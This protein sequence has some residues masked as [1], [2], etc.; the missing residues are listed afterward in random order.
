M[1]T[2]DLAV[3][4]LSVALVFSAGC[5]GSPSAGKKLAEKQMESA[6]N[7]GGAGHAKVDIGSSGNVDLSGL[8]AEFH[9]PGAVGIAHVGGGEA[10][11]KT[12]TYILQTDEAA[13]AVVAAYKQ[14]LSGWK[15]VGI[16]EAP[17]ATSITYETPDG[18]RHASVL[19][20]T[21]QGTGRTSINVTVGGR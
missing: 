18:K 5:S 10:A 21:D 1:R 4:A 13:G 16:M 17:N 20:G 6:L 15:Q 19:V 9:Q 3:L 2:N 11:E 8:P 7:Q 12:D 14:R